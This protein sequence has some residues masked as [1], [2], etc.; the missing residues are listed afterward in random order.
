MEQSAI[1]T[2]HF[3]MG[4]GMIDNCFIATQQI[5]SINTPDNLQPCGTIQAMQ[6]SHIN[7]AFKAARRAFAQWK[8]TSF[9]TRRL[10]VEK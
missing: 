9:T 4:M 1:K 2:S 10:L 5:V 8:R 6:R 7:V 3:S